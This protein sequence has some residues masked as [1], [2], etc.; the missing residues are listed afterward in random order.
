MVIASF[1][2]CEWSHPGITYHISVTSDGCSQVS[3]AWEVKAEFSQPCFKFAYWGCCSFIPTVRDLVRLLGRISRGS[4]LLSWLTQMAPPSS[5][6]LVLVQALRSTTEELTVRSRNATV[7]IL[8]KKQNPNAHVSYQRVFLLLELVR[9]F[10]AD[11]LQISVTVPPTTWEM[12]VLGCT[13]PAHQ[14]DFTLYFSEN[15]SLY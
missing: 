4:S 14:M 2:N 8:F 7:I 10:L 12:K 9:V 6:S 1:S 13:Q 5:E 11:D 15:W 3:R